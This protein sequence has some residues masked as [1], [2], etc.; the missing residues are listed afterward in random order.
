MEQRTDVEEKSEKSELENC[1]LLEEDVE[2]D[3]QRHSGRR[4]VKEYWEEG[5]KRMLSFMRPLF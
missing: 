2:E 1:D 4:S 5:D 3:E